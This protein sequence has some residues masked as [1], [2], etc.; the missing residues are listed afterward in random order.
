MSPGYGSTAACSG[1]ATACHVRRSATNTWRRAARRHTCSRRRDST[2]P[3]R[4][5]N[6][7]WLRSGDPTAT[8]PL[9]RQSTTSRS[10]PRIWT[11]D[12]LAEHRDVKVPIGGRPAQCVECQRVEQL[13]VFAQPGRGP[14]ERLGH[15]TS[16]DLLQQRQHLCAQPH[17]G[18]PRLGVVG[19]EPWHQPEFLAG[20]VGH[21]AA[22]AE[23]WPTP[24]R[25][26]RTH[27]GDR[28]RSRS[29]PKPEQH[30]FGLVVQ[31]VGD[32]DRPT[33]A[34]AVERRVPGRAGGGLGPTRR[35][36]LD[37]KYLRRNASQRDGLIAGDGG[38]AHRFGLQPVVD[39]QRDGRARPRG[40]C[41][42]GQGI[43][44]AGQRNAPLVVGG[45]V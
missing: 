32:Q 1:T 17:A 38:H 37:V 7:R 5:A 33:V 29:A 36:H 19:I 34:R 24:R 13:D 39:D 43:G 11:S 3:R 15:T 30:R 8:P 40:G 12:R 6:S 14:R 4:S 44:S 35:T 23:Q 41:G 20:A 10:T 31:G 28:A 45:A 18:E 16:E 42:Q 21:R 27:A 2:P 9:P 26:T 22:Y 25:I